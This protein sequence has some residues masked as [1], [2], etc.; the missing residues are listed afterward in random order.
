MVKILITTY[1]FKITKILYKIIEEK[2]IFFYFCLFWL[3]NIQ[4][5]FNQPYLRLSIAQLCF[6]SQWL[7]HRVVEVDMC[8][9]PTP[10][11]LSTPLHSQPVNRITLFTFEVALMLRSCPY[12]YPLP[13]PNL[14][15]GSTLLLCICSLI[16]SKVALDTQNILTHYSMDFL[17]IRNSKVNPVT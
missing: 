12:P 7:T 16:I 6:S 9:S 2:L 8:H 5:R 11:N 10:F 13:M 3:K 17:M 14:Y 1:G 4:I 15:T